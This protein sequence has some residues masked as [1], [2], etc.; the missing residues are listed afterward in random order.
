MIREPTIREET[1]RVVT[2]QQPNLAVPRLLV[3]AFSGLVAAGPMALVMLALKR[4]LPKKEQVP[5]PPRLIT[6][7]A[8]E[9]TGLEEQI[10]DESQ[11]VATTWLAHFGYGTLAGA[12]YPFAFGR[13]Q[14]PSLVKGLAFGLAV[15]ASGYLG[16]L[17][18]AN[19]LPPA[20]E[21]PMRRNA[22]LIA[23]HLVWGSIVALLTDWIEE[24]L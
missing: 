16:W 15:W 3:G 10:S 13:M 17:P 19:I 9:R 8:I 24:N 23:S 7:E 1:I 11:V 21:M 6:E 20:T 18:A 2:Y 12:V 4:T 5:L 14:A 22:V